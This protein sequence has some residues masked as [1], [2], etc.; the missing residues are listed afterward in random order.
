M[1]LYTNTWCNTGMPDQVTWVYETEE[2]NGKLGDRIGRYCAI[3][4]DRRRIY[5]IGND[6][7][8]FGDYGYYP[9][10]DEEAGLTTDLLCMRFVEDCEEL[11][12]RRRVEVWLDDI[13]KAMMAM[14]EMLGLGWVMERF[15]DNETYEDGYMIYSAD[16]AKK[17]HIGEY[18]AYCFSKES[19]EEVLAETPGARCDYEWQSVI[20]EYPNGSYD[21]DMAYVVYLPE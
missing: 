5:T 12:N 6:Y 15:T 1:K 16:F 2:P 10:A 20:M 11:F 13:A 17:A 4:A 19:V 7:V 3:S 18:V 14:S 21:E 8:W 9:E